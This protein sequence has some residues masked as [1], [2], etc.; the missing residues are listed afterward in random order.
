MFLGPAYRKHSQIDSD[1]DSVSAQ[2]AS[3]VLGRVAEGTQNEFWAA[4]NIIQATSEDRR[5]GFG[6]GIY[7]T[8]ILLFV[9][10]LLI[11]EDAKAALLTGQRDRA[12]SGWQMPYGMVQTG[13]GSAF[14]EFWY[15]GC[16]W[17]F[18]L[19]RLMRYLWA[20]AEAGDLTI[21]AVYMCLLTP[22]V[23]SAVSDMNAIFPPLF[24]FWAPLAVAA[25]WLAP[26]RRNELPQAA[27]A[28]A[29]Q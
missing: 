12:V 26:R 19:G 8:L 7:D 25:A 20:R 14:C 22:A 3:R 29:A 11:G 16:L 13:P 23:A 21:Q 2:D 28:E 10:K 27:F 17:F 9:P 24:M 18:G 6:A 4:A 5:Y 1:R 15:F